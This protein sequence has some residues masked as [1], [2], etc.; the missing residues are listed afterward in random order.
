MQAA[1]YRG[2]SCASSSPSVAQRLNPSGSGSPP[3]GRER[4]EGRPSTQPSTGRWRPAKRRRYDADWIHQRILSIRVP[5][6]VPTLLAEWQARAWSKGREY[7]ILTDCNYK[8]L[9]RHDHPA[10]QN[11]K[12]L[13]KGE[14]SGQH[15]S[16]LEIA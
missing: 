15:M 1:G 10:I 16:A 3:V 7:A 13:K 12:G 6:K 5:N 4:I 11:L 2:A 9:V 14:T 8:G